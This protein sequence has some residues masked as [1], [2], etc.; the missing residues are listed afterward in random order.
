MTVAYNLP[1]VPAHVN[2]TGPIIA[3]I[4]LGHGNG[5]PSMYRDSLYPPTQDGFGLNPVAGVDDSHHQYF[6]ESAVEPLHLAPNAVV[7]LSHLC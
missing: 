1:T 7:L 5:W 4:Y 6:G 3:N 2:L